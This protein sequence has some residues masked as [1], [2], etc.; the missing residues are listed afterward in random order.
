MNRP[1]PPRK[2]RGA[3]AKK[4]EKEVEL[5]WAQKYMAK[6]QE[7]KVTF[8][9]SLPSSHFAKVGGG[10]RKVEAP[11]GGTKWHKAAGDS[12]KLWCE[13]KNDD[14]SRLKTSGI[15]MNFILHFAQVLLSQQ[16]T[17]NKVGATEW[18]FLVD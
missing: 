11:Q 6:M 5:T 2:K 10:L 15:K 8:I 16:N 7:G 12:G 9:S 4:G 3:V 1:E 14:G 17:R 13:A 18:W